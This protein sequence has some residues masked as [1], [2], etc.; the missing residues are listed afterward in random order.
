MKLDILS[1]KYFQYFLSFGLLLWLNLA[2]QTISKK[3]KTEEIDYNSLAEGFL[4]PPDS[5]KPW[6]Y[7]YWINDD[8]SKEG[9][10]KDLEAMKKVGIGAALIGNINPNGVD[11][12][13]PLF[14]EEWWDILVHTVKEGKRLGVDIGLFNC[15]G[16]SQS[17]GPWVRPEMAMRYTVYSQTPIAG[18]KNIV[19]SLPQPTEEFQDTYVLAVKE[20]GELF[21]AS[22][23]NTQF[24]ASPAVNNTHFWSD[25]KLSTTP[26]FE[27]SPN[28]SY[29]I[30]VKTA[31]P[32][33]A[34]SL[35][36]TP[37]DKPI[38]CDCQLEGK[39]DNEY[40]LIRRFTFDRSNMNINVGAA[41]QGQ[42]A[43]SINGPVTDEFLLTCTNFKGAK[44]AGFSEIVISEEATLDHYVEKQMA[45]MHPTPTPDWSSYQ[46]V[47][48]QGEVAQNSLIQADEVLN[49]SSKMNGNGTLN[50]D[51]PEGE[52]T[53]YRFGMAPTGTKNA[54]SAPQG[55]G[56]EIDKMSE[57]LI[58]FHFEQFVGELLERLPED[59]KSAF[60]YVI[61]DSYEMGSQNW[62]D[63]FA[64]EFQEKYGYDPVPFLP[65][66]S[67]KIINSVQHSE[68]FLW[69]MRRLVADQ[70]AY[71]YVGGL[72]KI[73]NENGLKLWLENYG[74]WG[75]PSEFLMY[76]G[77]SNLV[78]GE[79]WN[80]GALGNI[81]CKA[82]S[83]AAHIY[84]K[85]VT[86]A[87]AFTAA[88]SSYLRHP[89]LL[90]K[91]GDWSFTEGIN[92]FVLH[93]YIQQPDDNRK[94]GVNAWFSTEFNRHNTWFE[95]SKSWM[96]YI[97][98]SQHM[99]TKGKYAADV[100]YFIGEDAP[101]MTGIRQPELPKGYSYDYINAEVLLE[102]A[103]VVD[104]TLTLPDGMSYGL[105]V[106]PPI[107]TMTPELI[108]KLEQMVHDGLAIYGPKPIQSPSLQNYP[109][110]DNAVKSSADKLWGSEGY[111]DQEL[112]R[113]VGQGFVMDNIS[114]LKALDH[115]DIHKDVILPEDAP[116]LWTH[117][118]AP[119]LDIYFL[120][121]Q[122][123]DKV[124]T[125]VTFEVK[126][127]LPELW[128]AVTG[129]IR[130]L[131]EFKETEE[132]TEVP[133]Q[134]E[135]L[136]SWFV[137]F[138]EEEQNSSYNYKENFPKSQVVKT[139][140][141]EWTLAFNNKDIGLQKPVKVEQL[142]DWTA[143]ENDSVKYY[144][145]T[146]DYKTTFTLS[147]LKND[148]HYQIDLGKV[149]VMATVSLNGQEVGTTWI[150]P[151]VLD[152]TDALKKGENILEIK[153]ANL[154]RNRIIRDLQ[155]PDSQRYTWTS[156]ND[157]KANE[158]PHSSG[159][160][161]P[162]TINEID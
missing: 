34:K 99:L 35:S 89:A 126:N 85:P 86:S 11:G 62:T 122:S 10:T 47:S 133:L 44:E 12:P 77:Q 150:K 145:G 17:G 69:D 51:A 139:I 148:I 40:R 7:W 21:T 106:L 83:S 20:N 161:G 97:R 149:S 115:L 22:A 6:C 109:E 23:N 30:R 107:Q 38:K 124:A 96:D 71:E 19:V 152:I 24:T 61:A 80:E 73:S 41:N 45:K 94:P 162:V 102:R 104:G 53:V 132:G 1:R 18:G 151:H 157:A 93:L 56:Y 127:K 136:E 54:P 78:S 74:H 95:Q 46:W 25:G 120:T 37:G 146:A 72:R 135:A 90:K 63:D 58:R 70:V 121:N 112:I 48:N 144:S 117:R 118:Q 5:V 50:W 129:E 153:V 119:N 79:F 98:R 105:L 128:N 42:V 116:V 160:L 123:E 64:R 154:W 125:K 3:L 76:G 113:S 91:R 57:E 16:W 87:E 31:R 137:V 65:V 156:V 15:P 49:L 88:H 143:F 28:S 155:L 108:T 26:S 114:L 92:H 84:G 43:L 32:I 60:K 75:F 67:G 59:S 55:R 9:V 81:E 147:E 68:R 131:P 36:L 138:T 66:Y 39:V 159:L 52:W 82:S 2:C 134:F 4:T 14:S 100:A 101:V 29:Q 141:S 103:Q 158:N 8:I 130:K 33:Q 13:V 140:D 27:L 142:M 110:S 111:Y